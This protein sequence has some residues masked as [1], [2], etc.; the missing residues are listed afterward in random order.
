M[1]PSLFDAK[2]KLYAEIQAIKYNE[3]LSDRLG[4]SQ[5]GASYYEMMEQSKRRIVE[6][7]KKDQNKKLNLEEVR[8]IKA[9]MG[10]KKPV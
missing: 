1:N 3:H 10:Y 4:I 8:K 5:A 2:H 7:H 6:A 9:E